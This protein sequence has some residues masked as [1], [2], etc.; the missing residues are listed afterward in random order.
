MNADRRGFKHFDLTEQAI[1]VFCAVYNELVH[2][3]L[4]SVYENAMAIAL[5]SAGM[6][7]PRR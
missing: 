1:G 4:E 6:L 2:G 3:F 5:R 7:R